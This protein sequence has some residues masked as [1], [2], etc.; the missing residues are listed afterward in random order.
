MAFYINKHLDV[1]TYYVAVPKTCRVVGAVSVVDTEALTG[2]AGTITLSDG[3]N[4]IGVITIGVE[5]AEG[6]VDSIVL[7]STTKGKVELDV[8]TPLKIVVAGCTNGEF[9]LTLLMDE[10]HADN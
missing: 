2:S 1:D 8:D 5:A 4:T 7:D 6:T 9:E 10:F 3:T